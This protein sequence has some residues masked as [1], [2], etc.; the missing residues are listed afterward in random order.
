[1]GR[2]FWKS[3]GLHLVTREPN[4]WLRVTPD[5]IRAYLTRPEVH[6]I[7][8][9]CENEVALFESLMDDPYRPV[10]DAELRA[11]ADPDA[12]E[13]YQVLL[14]YRDVLAR[15]TTLEGAY[16]SLMRGGNVTIPPVFIDQIVNVILGGM[17]AE[18][19]DPMQL[20]AG[21]LFFREQL[22]NI[23]DGKVMLADA[24]I[25]ELHA[26]ANGGIIGQ[27][28]AETNTPMRRVEL[29]VLTD[30][31]SAIYWDRSD[32]F[33]TVIDL[34]FSQPASHALARVIE[35]WIAHFLGLEV[36]VRPTQSI[37]DEAWRWHIGLDREATQILNDLYNASDVGEDALSRILALYRMEIRD[38]SRVL[39]DM[40]GKPVYLALACSPDKKV[41]L[42]PQNLLMNLPLASNA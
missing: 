5:L 16:L 23:G 35:A 42:K 11:I 31:N 1:L 6:P 20:R 32:R 21:E 2:D 38:R 4:G 27:L 37:K 39:A 19:T 15:A 34:R 24:E 28:L 9:S 41:R 22:A 29:D 26:G 14:D 18:A 12:A 30:D 40:Q 36:N 25:V 10:P 7:D 17:L 8:E 13:N 33:D 3:S